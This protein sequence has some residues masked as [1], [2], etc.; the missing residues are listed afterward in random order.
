MRRPIIAALSALVLAVS[1]PR[2][3]GLATQPADGGASSRT[4]ASAE[5]DDAVTQDATEAVAADL[6]AVREARGWTATQLEAYETSE[7]A[8]D[9]ITGSLSTNYPD[10]FVGSAL[11]DDPAEPPTVYV[12]GRAP[13]DVRA[14][15]SELGVTL[16]EDQP[17]SLDEVDVRL[18]AVRESVV[19]AG[20]DE[21]VV[22][23]DIQ[24]E[25]AI[26]LV[27]TIASGASVDRA[28]AGIPPDV[29][30]D[31]TVVIEDDPLAE[32]EGAFGGM[33]L[34]DGGV[35]ECTSG[36]TVRRLSDGVRG[37][38]GAGHCGGIE[39]I[40]HPGHAVHAAFFRQEHIGPAELLVILWSSAPGWQAT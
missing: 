33:K 19:S 23:A 2:Q 7:A 6:Q 18:A 30:K 5:L 38:T 27:V 3:P 37:V 32:L 35:S 39:Q 11:A 1:Q 16:I 14:L 21:F 15:A 26:T 8:L 28:L 4:Q 20:V 9:V 17:Y 29:A 13:A 10:A 25:G 34:Q 22:L 24:R 12:K 31:I 36:W 40:N